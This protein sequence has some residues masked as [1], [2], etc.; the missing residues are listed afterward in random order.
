MSGLLD[1]CIDELVD[2]L[3]VEGIDDGGVRL[4]ATRSNVLGDRFERCRSATRK[5]D[6]SS[7]AGEGPCDGTAD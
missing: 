6:I 1:H 2:C 5:E 4:A 3:L 7:L